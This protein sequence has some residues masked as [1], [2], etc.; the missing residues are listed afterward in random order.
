MI[1]EVRIPLLVAVESRVGVLNFPHSRLEHRL[2]LPSFLVL[3]L[4]L[5]GQEGL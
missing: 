1:V 3:Q 5:V 4:L 2:A